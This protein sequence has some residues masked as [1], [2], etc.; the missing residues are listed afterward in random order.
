MQS[1]ADFWHW[2]QQD[3]AT[4]LANAIHTGDF[5]DLPEQMAHLVN[6]IDKDLQWELGPGTQ[7]QHS[8]CVTANGDPALRPL[9]ERWLRAAPPPDTT[10]EYRAARQAD[11]DVLNQQLTFGDW[12]VELDQ[13]RLSLTVDEQSLLVDV[14]VHHPTFATMPESA[15][16]Q[17]AFLALTWLLGEDDLE[18][19]IGEVNTATAE[20][21]DALPADAL[22]ETVHAMAARHPEP[23]WV[24]MEGE[25]QDGAQLTAVAMRPLRWIDHPLLD[26]H[27]GI[28]LTYPALDPRDLPTGEDLAE[29]QQQEDD[30]LRLLDNAVLLVAHETGRGARTLHLYCDSTDA[31]TQATLTTWTQRQPNASLDTQP[32]PAWDQVSHLR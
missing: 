24:V 28:T 17:V 11:P 20:P 6:A 9:T 31:A 1:I 23:T 5:S 4:Q 25:G 2:W 19:W 14:T 3:G 32:D 8:L 13:T 7:A 30:L 26:L 10:W 22:P 27:A 12:E 29:L 21:A 16:L 15:A 18:R